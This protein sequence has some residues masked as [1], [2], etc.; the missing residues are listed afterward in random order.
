[1]STEDPEEISKTN[2][3]PIRTGFGNTQETNN[4][5]MLV[6]G[7]DDQGIGKLFIH[8]DQKKI[9]NDDPQQSDKIKLITTI[10]MS[11][12]ALVVKLQ[13]YDTGITMK[14]H[15]M[16]SQNTKS[17]DLIHLVSILIKNLEDHYPD[18]ETIV[19]GN[20]LMNEKLSEVNTTTF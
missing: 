7:K 4:I 13:N 6:T 20:S 8:D 9:G 3:V 16:I 2:L 15:T 17:T 18:A 5:M 10:L 12:S 1:M 11:S 14:F 19:I